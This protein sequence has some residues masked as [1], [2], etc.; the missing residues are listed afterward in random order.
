MTRRGE[1]MAVTPERCPLRIPVKTQM[2]HHYKKTVVMDRRGSSHPVTLY[3]SWAA[4]FSN[5]RYP[6]RH[7]RSPSPASPPG[8][9]SSLACP[10]LWAP[11][12]L[13]FN[14]R[15][16][17]QIFLCH[18]SLLSW[19]LQRAGTNCIYLKS[20]WSSKS[21]LHEEKKKSPYISIPHMLPFGIWGP[22]VGVNT[23]IWFDLAMWQI[24]TRATFQTPG[25]EI[26]I[27][28]KMWL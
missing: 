9:H 1:E 17:F 6:R 16:C 26:L 28:K 25:C 3:F 5:V 24:W 13:T 14:A 2:N 21:I 11:D 20:I 23:G 15:R 7:K 4:L 22:S 18:Y 19:L 10:L 12:L 27:L 8:I